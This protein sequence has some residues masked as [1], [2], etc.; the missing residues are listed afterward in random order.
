MNKKFTNLVRTIEVM[1][2]EKTIVSFIKKFSDGQEMFL[3][4]MCYWFA[5][6][7]AT[8]FDGV[9]YYEPV[10]NHFTTKIENELWDAS[11]KVTLEY[12][13]SVPWDEYKLED[14]L[15]TARIIRDCIN[16][17]DLD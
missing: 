6:I 16:K 5:H 11:G 2:K 4:G 10:D 7:L 8:R 15:H 3:Y 14:A 1:R 9:I 12:P 17:D 13:D